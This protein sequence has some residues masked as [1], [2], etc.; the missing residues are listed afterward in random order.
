ME[1]QRRIFK[2]GPFVL[3]TGERVLSRNGS[4]IRLQG[5]PYQ[6]LE[7]LLGRPGKLVT[8]DEIRQTL[9]PG[10]T[11]VD[12]EHGLNTSV[13]KLRLTL[14]DSAERSSYIETVRG[15]GYRF[16]VPV[17]VE[18]VEMPAPEPRAPDPEQPAQAAEPAI[19][20]V[21]RRAARGSIAAMLLAVTVLLAGGAFYLYHAHQQ[22]KRLTENDTV[23]LADFANSTGDAIFDDTLKTALR[24]SL[25]QSPFL[26]LQSDDT[27]ARTLQLMTRPAGTKLTPDIARDLCIRAGSKAY[28]AGAIGSLGSEYVLKL[29][30]V[31]C[32]TGVTLGEQQ[33]TAASKEKVLDALGEAASSLRGKLGESLTTVQRF[34]VPLEQATTPSLEALKALS[35]G[36]IASGRQGVAAALP[37][38]QRAIELDPNFAMGYRVV[39]GDYYELGEVGRAGEYLTKAFELRQHGSERE[40]L[41]IAA[42]Y[43]RNVTGE[44][45]NAAHALEEEIESYPRGWRAYSTLGAV[46]VEQGQYEK[47]AAITRQAMRMAPENG[48]MYG[49]LAN[50]T[51]ALQRVDETRQI[52][53]EA[54]ARGMMDDYP[55]HETLYALAFLKEDSSAIAQ[56]QKWFVSKPEYENFGLALASDT[57]A[58]AGHLGRA[59]DLTRQAVDS[60]VR[61]D[62]KENGAIWQAIGAQREAAFGHPAEGRR[63]A[64]AALKL[65]PTS[66]GAESEAA[67]AFAMTGD[68]A[69]AQALARDLGKRFPL[70]TQV[71]SLW[72]PTIQAQTALA[73]NNPAPA[74]TALQS[75][76]PVEFGEVLY[77]LNISCLYPA[78]VRGEAYLAAGQSTAAAVEYQKILDHSGVVW[79]CWTGPMAH[80]GVARANALLSRTAQGPDADAA[81]VRAI[82]AYK[83][84]LVLW[85]DADPDI[86]ILKEAKAEFAKLQ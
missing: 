81:R 13:K 8:R 74:L 35:L 66:P 61:G 43:Y 79:N 77:V 41:E 12:F 3:D 64:A 70:D 6:I 76:S 24:V 20:P 56:Q 83:K 28:I 29:K 39:G 51:L 7:I 86:P 58:Y 54:Q 47:A 30:A 15:F 85:K 37:L 60:A 75:A 23:V 11:Y 55:L 40:K 44:L 84:F 34:D 26:N 59:R 38:H 72:L 62:S 22:G 73:N 45:D 69:Q 1:S 18:I 68:T 17:E 4:R 14:G 2:F 33:I 82:A 80:L 5:Q 9:W 31:N 50:C 25:L 36:T 16:V 71:H 21:S 48:V 46:F 10:D 19:H 78:Y 63:M 27:V 42:A 53:Q 32:L 49:N 57:E 67:L 52:V 65:A